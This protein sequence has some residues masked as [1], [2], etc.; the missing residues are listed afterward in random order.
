MKLPA[1]VLR[2]ALA[3]ALAVAASCSYATTFFDAPLT[4]IAHRGGSDLRPEATLLAFG[5]AASLD[6][7]LI[8]EMDV[9]MS[10]DGQLVLMHDDTLE[11][12][13]SGHGAVRSLTE[14]QFTALT[15]KDDDGRALDAH[16]PILNV[17][18]RPQQGRSK[19]SL[20]RM[21]TAGR[22]LMLERGSE[23]FTLQ[24]VNQK[25]NVSI[26]SIYLRFQSKDNLV[27]AVIASEDAR[28]CSHHGFDWESLW[29]AWKRDQ[30]NARRLRGGST[31]TQQTAKNLFL[32]PGRSYLRKALE[33]PLAVWM[34]L[35][36]GKRRI[37]EIYLNVAQWGPGGQFGAQ[38]GARRA[39]G[40]SAGQDAC[41]KD[42]R[43]WKRAVVHWVE[44]LGPSVHAIRDY[45]KA[46]GLPPGLG[47]PVWSPGKPPASKR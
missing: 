26:G 36:L 29:A 12:T 13:T 46:N 1:L 34:D 25:G 7:D 14:A 19:A 2:S 4:V 30:S 43:G 11:R 45:W 17:S 6:P 47:V 20:E 21:L 24:D 27:R 31:I 32:W 5:H 44:R 9:R 3:S 37:M 18:R 42:R 41:H 38:A 23:D 35:V 33:L 16:P 15:L 10:S 39:F 22:A 28:F 8:L 40:K